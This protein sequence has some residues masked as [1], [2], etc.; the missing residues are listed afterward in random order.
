MAHETTFHQSTQQPAAV[1]GVPHGLLFTKLAR[2]RVRDDLVPRPRLLKLIDR[3]VERKLTLIS[4]GPGYGK[5]TLVAEWLA[6]TDMPAAWLSLDESDNEPHTFFSYL[7]ATLRTLDPELGIELDRALNGDR[8]PPVRVLVTTLINELAIITRPFVLILDD[9]HLITSPETLE[10]FALLVRHM[11]QMLRLLVI[12]RTDPALPLLRMRARGELFELR[13]DDLSF[14]LDE[15]RELLSGR[16]HLQ[17]RER[18]LREVQ[19]WAEGWPVG[20]LLVGQQMQ[21]QGPQ[22][23]QALLARL[24]GDIRF[25]QDYLWQETVEQQSP[26]RRQF[27]LQTSLLD[28]FNAS[29]CTALT[30]GSEAASMLKQMERENLFLIGFDGAGKWFRYHHLFADVLRERLRQEYSPEAV[31]ELHRRASA[32]YLQ[33][34]IAEDAARHA[35]DAEDWETA[36]PLLVQIC[37]ELDGQERISS[38]RQWLERVP[39]EV[40]Q[41][42][43]RLCTWFA[44][45]LVRHGR[46]SEALQL[47]EA[48]GVAWTPDERA[49]VL[50]LTLQIRMMQATYGWHVSQGLELGRQALHIVG[51]DQPTERSRLLLLTAILEE[52]RGDVDAADVCLRAMRDLAQSH[53]SQALRLMERNAAGGTLIMRGRLRDAAENLRHVIAAGDEWNDVVVQYAHW[54][55][56]GIYLEWNELDEADRVLRAGYD[57]TLKTNA[58]LHR[59]PLHQYFAEVAWARGDRIRAH[60]ELDRA[61]ETLRAV[62]SDGELRRANA[63]RARFWI[64]SNAMDEASV[65]VHDTGLTPGEEPDYSR[66]FEYLVLLRF[67]VREGRS[68]R[69][70]AAIEPAIENAER[71]GRR[72]DLLQLLLLRAVAEH[73]L[74]HEPA[75]V[76]ALQEAMAIGA[77]ERY[78]RSFLSLGAQLVPVLQAS[79]RLQQANGEV[80]QSL[81]NQMNAAGDGVD[82]SGLLSQ[83]ELEVIH[84]VAAG[85]S[86]RQIADHLFISEQ[87]VKKHVSNIFI[88]FSVASRTQAI[89]RARQL[90]I[91]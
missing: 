58:P 28:Q 82:S 38:L 87:T 44:W 7:A 75:A 46:V 12:T 53:T 24:G 37:A 32:W 63:R 30:A 15:T 43:P 26:E 69:A 20:L 17:L 77:P 3:G 19:E 59:G 1:S 79:I 16:F 89:V 41:R 57:V 83:R 18:E 21:D 6:T 64:E 14:T 74:G 54:V 34:G 31:R 36:L 22:E 29:L 35:L 68:E 76:A 4:G 13:A 40:L 60:E 70:L 49:G 73:D 90:G 50:G 91:I 66:F 67:L 62:G 84:L 56:A 9:L 39:P 78:A 42:E 25:V 2:P 10:G 55:L 45:A 5:S 65:W 33:H 80:A 81:L 48:G 27:L 8:V 72:G 88:K 51:N 47:L 11:P 23:R 86:N 61:V 71:S 52:M 85:E